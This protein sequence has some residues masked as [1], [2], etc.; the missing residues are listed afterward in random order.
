MAKLGNI[1]SNRTPSI[2]SADESKGSGLI[3]DAILREDDSRESQLASYAT[4][5]A[6]NGNDHTI[7]RNPTL[8]L[9]VG[10]SDNPTKV[11]AAKATNS[12]LAGLANGAGTA[13]SGLILSKIG[14][15]AAAAVGL[16]AT[17]GLSAYSGSF[18]RSITVYDS[19]DD[20]RLNATTVNVVGTKRDYKGYR[21]VHLREVTEKEN[22]GGGIFEIRLEQPR[23]FA[24]KTSTTTINSQLRQ[25]DDVSTRGQADGNIGEVGI[26]NG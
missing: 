22:E 15:T 3:F 23:H 19:L 17:G 18:H 10:V 25:N 7:H 1:I 4:E 26:S 24:T 6:F 16:A 12:T 21:I 9:Q 20:M 8:L 14:G 13:A 2:R 11:A 5:T